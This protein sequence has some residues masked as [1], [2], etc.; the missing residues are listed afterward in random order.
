MMLSDQLYVAVLATAITNL[1]QK[2]LALEVSQG[3]HNRKKL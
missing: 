1:N 3:L 2:G